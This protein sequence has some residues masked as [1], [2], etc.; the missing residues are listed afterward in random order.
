ML[1]TSSD[2]STT[3]S[4]LFLFDSKILTIGSLHTTTGSNLLDFPSFTIWLHIATLGPF[5][6]IGKCIMRLRTAHKN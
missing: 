6:G 1:T 5:L 3:G 2:G 4:E